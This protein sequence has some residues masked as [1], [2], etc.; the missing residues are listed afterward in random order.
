MASLG[1]ADVTVR[2]GSQ[3]DLEA[4]TAIKVGSWADTYS[5]LIP[6]AVLAPFLDLDHALVDLR[7]STARPDALFLVAED[8][9][10]ALT[11]FALAHLEHGPEPWLESLHVASA[12]RGRGVG[13]ALARALA[14]LL[15]AR[16]YRTMSLGVVKGNKGAG[17][18]YSRLGATMVGI[19][20]TDWADGVDHEVY[21]WADLAQLAR[22]IYNPAR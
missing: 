4:V 1:S 22:G 9:G 17:R 19:E 15:V 12:H 21:R 11:G 5:A 18:L 10:G 3:A 8:A 7:E 16:G 6:Q 14:T 2:P 13:T 20:P